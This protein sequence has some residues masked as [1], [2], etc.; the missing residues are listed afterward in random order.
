MTSKEFLDYYKNS[1]NYDDE[2]A[3]LRSGA[4]LKKRKKVAKCTKNSTYCKTRVKLRKKAIDN[5]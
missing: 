3:I 5:E 2:I 1:A 4:K